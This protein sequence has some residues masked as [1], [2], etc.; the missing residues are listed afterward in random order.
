MLNGIKSEIKRIE[1]IAEPSLIAYK[2]FSIKFVNTLNIE[3]GLKPIYSQFVNDQ[4][5]LLIKDESI[6]IK[7]Y[8]KDCLTSDSEIILLPYLFLKLLDAQIDLGLLSRNILIVENQIFKKYP[9][10]FAH[11]LQD[12]EVFIDNIDKVYPKELR[13][14]NQI[15]AS[16]ENHFGLEFVTYLDLNY[17]DN[18]TVLNFT[19][20][21]ELSYVI[22]DDVDGLQYGSEDYL[23]LL[24]ELYFGQ[25]KK[26]DSIAL[27]LTAD[28]LTK[29]ISSELAL[30]QQLISAS[31]AKLEVQLLKKEHVKTHRQELHDILKKYWSSEQFRTIEFY[32]NP[33]ENNDVE[34]V[35]Q[36]AIVEKI[37]A[38][39]EAAFKGND[40]HDVFV[41]APTGSGKSLLYQ[42]PA[43][44]LSDTQGLV[45]IVVSPL[46]ALMEDQIN[47]LQSKGI[48]EAT[49]I[50]SNIS[51][52][53]REKKI[54]ALK[55]GHISI[56]Y[57]SPELLLSYD[58]T[59]FIG[60]RSIGLFVVDEAH[61]VTTWGRDFRVDYWFIGNYIEK[62][63]NRRKMKFPIAAFTATAAYGGPNDLVFETIESLKMVIRDLYIGKARRDDIIF[64]V[65]QVSYTKYQNER[66]KRTVDIINEYIENNKK[67]LIYFPWVQQ[68]KKTYSSLDNDTRDQVETYN[69]GMYKQDKSDVLEGFKNGKLKVVLA[70]KAFG[71][72]VDISD[73]EEV[74]HHAP[75][76]S[77]SDYIQEIGRVARR[78]DIKGKA[79]VDFSVEDLR[80]AKVLYGLSAIKQWEV[81]AALKKIYQIYLQRNTRN[82][83]LSIEDF[84]HIFDITRD[85][86]ENKVKSALVLIE[87]DL[88]KK[89]NYPAIIVRPKSLFAEVYC[90]VRE[91]RCS[92]FE[93]KYNRFIDRKIT[94]DLNY[95]DSVTGRT[96]TDNRTI[97][98]IRLNQF[99]ES[100]EY[101]ES[102]PK[103]KADFF[104]GELFKEFRND[105]HPVYELNIQLKKPATEIVNLFRH[106]LRNLEE[107]FR[108]VSS[109]FFTRADF[110]KALEVSVSSK[111]SRNE[112]VDVTLSIFE[113][114]T[115]KSNIKEGN[116][117]YK[118][119]S[120]L[121]KKRDG[122][123]Y[124]Y[125][126]LNSNYSTLSKI[127][128]NE[129]YSIFHDLNSQLVSHYIPFD[130]SKSRLQHQTAQ[131]IEAFNLG[132]FEL[133]G[134]SRPLLFIRVND[135]NK[136]NYL[137]SHNYQNSIV[138]DIKKR[139]SNSMEIMEL[140]FM[141]DF[142]TKKR[143]DF[144]ENYFLGKDLLEPKSF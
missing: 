97:F 92:E 11:K 113:S 31:D 33:D 95:V 83:L 47:D 140:F 103:V 59:H 132:T 10:E 65:N 15:C 2:G 128:V 115:Y 23:K 26:S 138:A 133:V 81:N 119:L 46:I 53:E 108:K 141:S 19:R 49:F 71:M 35:S 41:T 13:Y 104:S 1:S 64:D 109:G 56:L 45:T 131:L 107:A 73:I 100:M 52:I 6:D 98:K 82:F 40:F 136:I 117:T 70:S 114:P 32:S 142:D 12:T 62:L 87:Q 25:I 60:E 89:Y 118:K 38:E 34:R 93:R 7:K 68:I 61:L 44:Y 129:F 122:D 66:E 36:G 120:F 74:Y 79:K 139:H 127:L 18:L 55:N 5:R 54:E 72:G 48:Y 121:Q 22:K 110:I 137:V 42:I 124:I 85:E 125:R 94:N 37:T 143:W 78:S 106:S 86:C 3:L 134:G 96:K 51:F 116:I 17:K 27:S 20:S 29:E 63:R 135:P 30:L 67:A 144:I 9:N 58:I 91:T 39:S 84:S 105:Y 57:L 112:L 21:A 16:V 101:S 80:Y 14:L 88:Q 4:S 90:W 28:S 99:W 24:M 69:G 126:I 123:Q 50:N 43:K 76:G 75:S 102:F 111:K 8:V 130:L 77:L